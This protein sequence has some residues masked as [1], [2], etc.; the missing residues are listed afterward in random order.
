MRTPDKALLPGIAA[1]VLVKGKSD[2]WFTA[3]G[4]TDHFPL[5]APEARD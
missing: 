2:G 4:L 5:G 3:R 1:T